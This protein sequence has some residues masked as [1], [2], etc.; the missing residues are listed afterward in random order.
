MPAPIFS[1]GDKVQF[2]APFVDYVEYTVYDIQY[3]DENNVPVDEVT[4]N[5]QY[6]LFGQTTVSIEQ[7]LEAVP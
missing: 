6:V 1:P 3:L 2:T 5:F 7:Y 4:D